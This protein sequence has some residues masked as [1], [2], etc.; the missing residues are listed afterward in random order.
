MPKSIGAVRINVTEDDV[1]EAINVKRRLRGQPTLRIAKGAFKKGLVPLNYN[2]TVWREDCLNIGHLQDLDLDV[3]I[4]LPNSQMQIPL[5]DNSV[6]NL[7]CTHYLHKVHADC[8]LTHT[9]QSLFRVLSK[10]GTLHIEVPDM[11]YF[12]EMAV[13]AQFSEVEALRWE[14]F[15]FSYPDRSGLFFN[16]SLITPDRI[17]HRATYAGF[18]TVEI[19]EAT[20]EPLSVCDADEIDIYPDQQE[21]ISEAELKETQEKGLCALYLLGCNETRTIKE[22]NINRSRYCRRHRAQA[23]R[24][25]NRIYEEHYAIKATIRKT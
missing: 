9:F 8:E 16:Q 10:K 11:M 15:M 19:T 1:I 20:R 5:P 3:E 2:S 21:Q 17:Q 4:A 6:K 22:T 13:N 14:H 18:K 12:A 7:Y 23:V 24:R 25:F